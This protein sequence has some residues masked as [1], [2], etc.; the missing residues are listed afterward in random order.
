[1]GCQSSVIGQSSV[2]VF[3]HG[4]QLVINCQLWSVIISHRLSVVVVVSHAV[5]VICWSSSVIGHLS[6]SV[7][8]QSVDGDGAEGGDGDKEGVNG[9]DEEDGDRGRGGDNGRGRGDGEDE[10]N[11]R[12]RRRWQ[13]MAEQDKRRQHSEDLKSKARHKGK[14]SERWLRHSRLTSIGRRSTQ[15]REEKDGPQLPDL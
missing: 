11:N 5:M 12:K 2:V 9:A 13:I 10:G 14:S 15:K 7:N 4:Q 6:S 1:M 8:H 3:G